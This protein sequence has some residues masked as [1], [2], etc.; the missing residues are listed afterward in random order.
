[1]TVETD[2]KKSQMVVKGEFDPATLVSFLYRRAG[3]HVEILKQEKADDGTKK[4]ENKQGK[5]EA[6]EKKKKGEG[7]EDKNKNKKGRGE[8][9][10]FYPPQIVMEQAYPPQIFSDENVH[11]CSVM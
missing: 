10:F 11:A 5:G 3:K 1:M 7:G 9:L 4:A 8:E 6:V 2:P